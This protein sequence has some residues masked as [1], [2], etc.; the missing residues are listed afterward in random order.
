MW[1]N[2]ARQLQPVRKDVPVHNEGIRAWKLRVVAITDDGEKNL[3]ILDTRDALRMA[4]EQGLDLV[5]INPQVDPPVAKIMDMGKWLYQKS[6]AEKEKRAAERSRGGEVHELTM[7][8]GI[9]DHDLGVKIRKIQE[10]VE[11]GDRVKITIR[12]RG[13]ENSRAGDLGKDLIEKIITQSGAQR[14]GREELN[15]NRM[16]LLLGR[17]KTA[18]K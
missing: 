8:P 9:D 15:G 12:F 17:A 11:N 6:K 1:L 14:E 16:S 4:Q 5:V 7:R 3:G 13:R 2:M 10:W 18:S